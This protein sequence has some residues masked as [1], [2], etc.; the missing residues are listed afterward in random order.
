MT[1]G[2]FYF[3]YW[4]SQDVPLFWKGYTSTVYFL[5]TL[6]V[7][8]VYLQNFRSTC[9]NFCTRVS[10]GSLLPGQSKVSS[11]REEV[12]RR[13]KAGISPRRKKY[14]LPDKLIEVYH[15]LKRVRRRTSVLQPTPGRRKSKKWLSQGKLDYEKPVKILTPNKVWGLW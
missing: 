14:P 13:T 6:R 12:T 10:F 11:T 5:F 9:A 4:T 2:G 8:S 1:L 15:P 3:I 7:L